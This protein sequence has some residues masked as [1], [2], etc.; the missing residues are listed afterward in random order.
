MGGAALRNRRRM[1]VADVVCVYRGKTAA[2]YGRIK[3]IDASH[4]AIKEITRFQPR[5]VE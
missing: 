5:V 4:R 1:Q 2:I 3:E